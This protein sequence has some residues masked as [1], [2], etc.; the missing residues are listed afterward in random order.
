MTTFVK[1]VEEVIPV[2]PKLSP[3]TERVEAPTVGA[4]EEALGIERSPASTPTRS[5]IVKLVFE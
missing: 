5:G 3:L 2:L 4:V 1:G